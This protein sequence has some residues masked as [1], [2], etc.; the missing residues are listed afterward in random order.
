VVGSDTEHQ[1]AV[2]MDEPF[3]LVGVDGKVLSAELGQAE[4][5]GFDASKADIPPRFGAVNQGQ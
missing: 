1:P 5:L 2:E 4:V 3:E